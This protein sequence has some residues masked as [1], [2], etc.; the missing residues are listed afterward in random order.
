LN[1]DRI[2]YPSIST[3]RCWTY[4][5][6]VFRDLFYQGELR[7]KEKEL[8]AGF[9]IFSGVSQDRLSEIAEHVEV[10]SYNP[11]EAIFQEG[12]KA[13]K[14]YGV[15]SGEVELV[16]VA[17]DS[18]LKTDVQYEEYTHSRTETVERDIVIDSVGSGELLGWSALIPDGTYTSKAV[19]G[20]PTRVV[21]IP[22]DNLRAFFE[23]YPDVGYP[24]M[25]GIV[26]I[27]SQRLTN[28]TDRLIDA[29]SEAFN[30]NRI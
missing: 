3:D 12:V 25:E 4:T 1:Y 13:S 17:K 29:W 24:F 7:M 2:N 21:A 20:E 9:S 16:L 23:K 19:C 22:A 28:R 15:I 30:V 18:I 11:Q 5:K 27:I 6:A 8:I 14:I 26:E 10:L